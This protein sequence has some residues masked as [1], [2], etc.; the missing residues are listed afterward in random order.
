M[1]LVAEVG[2]PGRTYNRPDPMETSLEEVTRHRVK[3]SVDVPPEEARPVLDTAYR[4]VGAAVKIP[5]FRKGKVPRKVIDTQVGRG[6]VL[7]EFL[8][9]G[10]GKFYVAALREHDLAPIGDPEFGDVDVSDIE[11]GGFRFTVTVDVRPRLRFED[12][13]Y[14]GLRLERPAPRVSDADVDEQL[15]RLRERFAELDVAAHAARRGDYVVIDLR[16]SVHGEELPELT[17]QDVLYEVGSRSMVPELDDEVEGK[18]QGDILKFN[19]TLPETAGE[20][21][22]QDVTFQVLVKEV[23]EKRLA[24]LDDDFAKTASEFDTLDELRA[25]VRE[26]LSRLSAAAA[27]AALRDRALE[28]LVEKVDVELPDALIDRETESRV[29]SAQARA[30][31][32]GAT[33]EQVLE[34]SG[35]EELRFRAD[36]R[37][38]AERAIRADLALEAVAR[39]AELQVT[40]EELDA[41]VRALAEQLGR[42][43]KQVRRSLDAS[44]Q[45]TSLAGDIIRDRALDL[46]IEHAEVVDE[47]GARAEESPAEAEGKST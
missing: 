1:P 6:E 10:L 24:P 13:D 21:A 45:I 43:H 3:L 22:G 23:K 41:A 17:G 44:G 25:D 26:K 36:A 34:A 28:V 9:H 31:R 12:A 39:A 2:S 7:K 30:E 32:Q 8:E 4:H 15:D 37:S 47:S 35:V 29:Q 11:G 18:R 27:D 42:D 40:E 38:H 16:G 14:K 19:S 46:V 5:G 33:L 20:R